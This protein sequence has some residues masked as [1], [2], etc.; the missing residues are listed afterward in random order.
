MQIKYIEGF[1]GIGG[2]RLGFEQACAE[3]KIETECA[4]AFEKDKFAKQT[5][6][7]NFGEEPAGDITKIPSKDIPG[8]KHKDDT[9][10]FFAGFPCQPWSTAGKQKGVNDERDMIPQVIRI[11]KDK[12]PDVFVLENVKGLKSKKFKDVYDNLMHDLKVVCGYTVYEKIYNAKAVVPQNRQR[13]F[14]VGFKN[15][16]DFEFPELPPIYPVLKDVLEFENVPEKYFLRESTKKWVFNHR[17]RH[18]SS[19]NGGFG[20][21]IV[22]VGESIPALSSR[23]DSNKQIL[24]PEISRWI[25]YYRIAGIETPANTI[26]AQYGSNGGVATLISKLKQIGK[27]NKGGQGQRIYDINGLS[28]TLEAL[29]GGQGAKTGLYAVPEIIEIDGK[30]Y[31][32]DYSRVRKLLPRECARTM[33]FS[34]DFKIVV[35]DSQAYRQFGNAV[36]PAVVKEICKAVIKKSIFNKL[37]G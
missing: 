7:A 13:I 37:G 30:K 27:I 35:S 6:F 36:V 17:E 12:R 14:I 32:V 20:C 24:V 1:A 22:K 16:T 21:R 18:A 9:L 4:F 31:I 8:R 15:Q 29:G 3:L 26:T 10:F 34:D 2:F 5:Y 19:K 25:P 33:G 11:I 23:Y 28:V